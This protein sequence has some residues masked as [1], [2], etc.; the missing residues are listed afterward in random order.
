MDPLLNPIVL[1]GQ[2]IGYGLSSTLAVLLAVLAWQSPDSGRHARALNA[3]CAAVWSLGGLARFGLL[4][5]GLS[6]QSPILPWI[7]CLTFSAAAV[8]PVCLLLFWQA[9]AAT[10]RPRAARWL[11]AAGT[12]AAVA[13]VAGLVAA[14]IEWPQWLITLCMAVGYN[15][16]MLLI[17]AVLILRPRFDSVVERAAVVLIPGGPLASMTAHWIQQSAM[18]P[19]RWD[20]VLDVLVKQSM[21]LTLLGVL[22]YLGRFQGSDRFAKLGLRV[23]WA[24]TLGIG[25]AWMLTRSAAGESMRSASDAVSAAV[26]CAAVAAAVLLFGAFAR[27]S[28]RWVD[29]RVFGRRD[30]QLALA[31]LRERL[32][33]QEADERVCEAAERFFRDTLKV[34]VGVVAASQPVASGSR[35]P[36]QVGDAEPLALAV[37]PGA[38]RRL[39]VS[40]EVDLLRQGAQVVGR[41]LEAL[42]RER[43]R[44]ELSRRE[45]RL[46]HQ[47]V[48]AELRALRAQINPHFLFNSLNTI[49]A[50][51]H[52]DPSLAEAMTLRLARI[53]RYVLTQTDQSF[54]P[55]H[56]EID[57]LRTYLDIEQ[58]RFGER[59]QVQFQV[60]EA[61]ADRPIP[62]L[63]LQPLVENAIKHGFSPKVGPCR[64]VIGGAVRGEQLVLTVEDDGVGAQTGAALKAPGDGIGLRN[65]RE[66]LA[67]VYGTRA[68]LSFESQPRRGSRATVYLPLNDAATAPA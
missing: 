66:R 64:L 43:E 2:L 7:T 55:L 47:L 15:A 45:G 13:L 18:L 30:P 9:S 33:Q 3:A 17:G 11:L 36:V 12:A 49:A 54:T 32:A 57:F 63:I 22:V 52:Q 35:F 26:I 67:T 10:R 31:E 19:A 39:L 37:R 44:I 23:V 29:R 46:M 68:R 56:E 5:A 50:L 1:F 40:S 62:S 24:W 58:M 8:W 41:R 25:L 51:V 65:V 61:V 42:A 6:A 28:D 38:R 34:E 59:L 4:A 53:F 60:A 16:L 27:A 21:V 14:T 20:P 48:Q